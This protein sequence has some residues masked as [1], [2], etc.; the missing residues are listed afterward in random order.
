MAVWLSEDWVTTTSDVAGRPLAG[1]IRP[2]PTTVGL[3]VTGLPG[4]DVH[5]H[6][7]IESGRVT[8]S[9]LG[10]GPAADV[11]F[12]ATA[13][14]G[15]G[16]VRGEVD[17]SVAFM[18]GRLKTAGDPGLVLTVLAAWSSPAGRTAGRDVDALTDR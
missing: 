11:S 7:T 13:A 9:G 15:M 5:Y 14:D 4:G 16:M 18:Q 1:V 8:S 3:T 10:A 6:R 12:T 2:E 17:P